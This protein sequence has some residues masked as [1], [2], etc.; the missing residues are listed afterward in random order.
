MF[1]HH[2]RPSQPC[3]VPDPTC[4][5]LGLALLVLHIMAVTRLAGGMNAGIPMVS[6]AQPYI[7]WPCTSPPVVIAFR[8]PHLS[9]SGK[10]YCQTVQL[11]AAPAVAGE[12]VWREATLRS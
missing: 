11:L 1:F 7:A 6:G 2:G 10:M 8:A 9:P 5:Q 4:H 12:A 3:Q